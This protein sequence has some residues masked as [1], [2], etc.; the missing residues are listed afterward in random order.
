MAS[1]R[2]ETK[3]QQQRKLVNK[4]K[5]LKSLCCISRSGQFLCKKEWVGDWEIISINKID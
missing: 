5:I 1:G 4:P 3:L 2:N